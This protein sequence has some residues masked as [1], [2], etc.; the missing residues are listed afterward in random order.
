MKNP[1]DLHTPLRAHIASAGMGALYA[2]LLH[3]AVWLGFSAASIAVPANG[4]HLPIIIVPV[5]VMLIGLIAFVVVKSLPPEAMTFYAVLLLVHIL[6]SALFLACGGLL[7]DALQSLK[8][9][10]PPVDSP[11]GNLSWLYFI[12]VWLILALGQGILLFL[13][14]VI[15]TV[16]DALRKTM[17][18]IP[19]EKK[20]TPRD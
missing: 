9:E 10:I 12:L 4:N 20:K 1:I 5:C 13:L 7:M 2:V 11:E 16:R 18:Y 6:V 8:G 17:G 14:A 19:K 3:L 15:F